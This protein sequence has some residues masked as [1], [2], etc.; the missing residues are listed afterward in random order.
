MSKN[1]E[2]RL[3]RIEDSIH[4]TKEPAVVEIVHFTDTLPPERTENGITVRCVCF[5][6]LKG[7]L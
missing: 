2:S 4:I 5:S 6:D 7:K 3:K 1:I